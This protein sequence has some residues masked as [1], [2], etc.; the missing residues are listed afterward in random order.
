MMTLLFECSANI[1]TNS[2]LFVNDS[3]SSHKYVVKVG[4]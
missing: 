1:H 3:L 4:F 2:V